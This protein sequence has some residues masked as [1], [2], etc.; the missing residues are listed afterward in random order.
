M[1]RR[2]F[3]RDCE[4][5][6]QRATWYLNYPRWEALFLAGEIDTG[7]EPPKAP[8]VVIDGVPQEEMEDYEGT[9]DVDVVDDYFNN[10]D[11]TREMSGAA[12]FAAIDGGTNGE[13]V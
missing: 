6:I 10:L 5:I 2:V 8:P 11:K 13:W 12:L 1:N 9:Y 4:D 3:S 7:E